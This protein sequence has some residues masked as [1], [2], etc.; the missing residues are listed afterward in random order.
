MI[1]EVVFEHVHPTG[2]IERDVYQKSLLKEK[3]A[4]SPGVR[5][6]ASVGFT[7]C[8]TRKDVVK[9]EMLMRTEHGVKSND[10]LNEPS[11]DPSNDPSK[12]QSS[13]ESTKKYKT[14]DVL[15]S[16]IPFMFTSHND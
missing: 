11:N 16:L 9:L 15:V 7:K 3:G 1:T 10:Q 6:P 8:R 13:E 14:F 12:D 5:S 2:A 4:G